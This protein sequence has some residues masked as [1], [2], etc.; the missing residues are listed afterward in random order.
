MN[1]ILKTSAIILSL[2]LTSF[3]IAKAFSEPSTTDPNLSVKV[4]INVGKSYQSK[5]G[6]LG[7]NSGKATDGLMVVNTNSVGQE[8]FAI[9][10]KTGT[11]KLHLREGNFRIATGTLIAASDVGIP[12]EYLTATATGTGM[13]WSNIAWLNIPRVD[14]VTANGANCVKVWP[15]CPNGWTEY[16]QE[17]M[18]DNCPLYNGTYK[19]MATRI[20]YQNFTPN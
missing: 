9:G 17:I 10:I 13:T 4:P 3:V 16:S 6:G 5:L 14:V 11:E 12:D 2:V 15:T 20:C 7:V 19:Y 8:S 18:S 1:K